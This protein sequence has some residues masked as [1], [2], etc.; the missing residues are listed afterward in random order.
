[1]F[2]ADWSLPE[3]MQ[4]KYSESLLSGATSFGDTAVVTIARSGGEGFDLPRDVNA[5]TS[6]NPYQLHQQLR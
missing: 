3:P 5:E 4:D 2:K 6:N 1:M